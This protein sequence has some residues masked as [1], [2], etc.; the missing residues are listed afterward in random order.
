MRLAEKKKVI[1]RQKKE[2]ENSK[3]VVALAGDSIICN[4]QMFPEVWRKYFRHNALNLGIGGDRWQHVAQRMEEFVLPY[5]IKYVVVH[6]GTNNIELDHPQQVAKGIVS[7]GKILREKSH[8][9]ITVIIT[10]L[11]P[12]DLE[13]SRNREKIKVTNDI[14]EIMCE[15]LCNFKFLKQDSDW[16][17]EGGLL[18]EKLFH[19]DHL[20]LSHLGNIKFATCIV[21]MIKELD[22]VQI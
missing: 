19:T 3:A 4:L 22:T 20:H 5:T 6:C 8:R 17:L 10:G 13:D 9:P 14:L 21:A 16:V 18:N 15:R 11:L 2:A 7:C 12:R 1:E